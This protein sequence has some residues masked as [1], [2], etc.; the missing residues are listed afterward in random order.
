[1]CWISE[2]Y[3]EPAVYIQETGKITAD[4]VSKMLKNKDTRIEECEGKSLKVMFH[5]GTE[6]KFLGFITAG[7]GSR[8]LTDEDVA[9][10]LNNVEAEE[11]VQA[12]TAD[13]LVDMF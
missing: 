3:Y 2:C 6:V 1:M 4:V 5:T 11:I 8:E 13:E 10:I 12:I 7:D 9:Y